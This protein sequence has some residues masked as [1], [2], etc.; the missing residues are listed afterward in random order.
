MN[1]RSNPCASSKRT[2]RQ[3]YDCAVVYS[4]ARVLPRDATCH[5][6][7]S[8]D[9]HIDDREPRARCSTRRDHRN[10]LGGWAQHHTSSCRRR[11]RSVRTRHSRAT[12]PQLGVLRR[13]HVD[14]ARCFKLARRF[15]QVACKIDAHASRASRTSASSRGLHSFAPARAR[16]G[17]SRSFRGIRAAR[18]FGPT[19]R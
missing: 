12:R 6:F 16:A 14:R 1:A 3:A 9:R 2:P 5:R 8:R 7:R 18:A 17:N 13:A 19:I 11:D 15:P 4:C 10:F